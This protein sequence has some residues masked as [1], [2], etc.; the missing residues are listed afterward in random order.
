MAGCGVSPFCFDRFSGKLRDLT[1]AR[2]I[3]QNRIDG[4]AALEHFFGEVVKQFR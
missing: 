1:C 3:R 4:T 2:G